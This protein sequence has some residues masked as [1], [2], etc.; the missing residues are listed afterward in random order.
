MKK[1]ALMFLVL[2][3]LLG[4]VSPSLAGQLAGGYAAASVTNA[5]VVAAAQF[6]VKTLAAMPE[7]A[8]A[9]TLVEILSASQQ[10]VAGTN[11][12]LRL[13]LKVDGKDSEVEVVVWR[14]LNGEHQ[15]TSQTWSQPT[16]PAAPPRE[17]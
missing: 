17:N 5:Q 1:Y 3:L 16:A 2:P 15:L 7:R 9:M 4:M 10:I 12:R 13:K 8:P 6:A 11:Y 14:K